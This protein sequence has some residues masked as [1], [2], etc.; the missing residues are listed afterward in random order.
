GAGPVFEPMPTND[1]QPTADDNATTTEDQNNATTTD[2]SSDPPLEDPELAGGEL[3][4]PVEGQPPFLSAPGVPDSGHI[5]TFN[6]DT[7]ELRFAWEPSVFADAENTSTIHYRIF[8]TDTDT[9]TSLSAGPPILVTET[10]ETT[11]AF[12]IRDIGKDYTFGIE[13]FDDPQVGAGD[14]HISS[15]T[16]ETLTVPSFLNDLFFYRLTNTDGDRDVLDLRY[17]SPPFIPKLDSAVAQ[18]MVFYINREPNPANAIL[19]NGIY[20]GGFGTQDSEG[21]L[22]QYLFR[23]SP[24]TVNFGPLGMATLSEITREDGRYVLDLPGDPATATYSPSDYVTVAYYSDVPSGG[25]DETFGLVA[26]DHVKRYFTG[27]DH[28]PQLPPTSPTVSADFDPFHMETT[29][30]WSDVTDPD[31]SSALFE[32][33]YGVAGESLPDAWTAMTPGTISKK[34]PVTFPN[35][36]T[37]SVRAKDPDGNTSEPTIL[38]WNFPDG[39]APYLISGRLNS[40]SQDFIARASGEAGT[41]KVFSDN[42]ASWDSGG[43]YCGVLLYEI[44]EDGSQTLLEQVGG[45]P[46]GELGG[47]LGN[48]CNMPT[49]DFATHPALIEGGHY[50]WTFKFENV[51]NTIQF[52][53]RDTDTAGGPFSDTTIANALFTL[54]TTDGAILAEVQ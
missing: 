8:Q 19:R 47:A 34:I 43:Y 17:D 11:F 7:I 23:L 54:K 18:G 22:A 6:R 44:A 42:Y 16:N 26:L 35:S 24:R 25:S 21:T 4:E 13:A 48:Q 46:N 53:G 30:R 2:D 15:S 32:I 10:D 14:G 31:S 39:F 28:P 41:I 36:Y 9:S 1:P 40:A 45:E 5:V 29:F 3:V 37:F 51:R 27:S 33:N 50:R 20:G 12:S 52:Y 38:N 49:F